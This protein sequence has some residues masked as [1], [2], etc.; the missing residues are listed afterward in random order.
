MWLTI[1]S[2]SPRPPCVRVLPW[3]A[4]WKCSNAWGRNSGLI[5]MPVVAARA[6][7]RVSP[8]AST[9]TSHRARPRA[10][11]FT[12]LAARFQTTCCSRSG[13]AEHA[14]PARARGPPP[15]WMRRLSRRG[16]HRRPARAPPPS[17]GRPASA[18]SAACRSR[19]ARRRAGP[20]SSCACSRALRS[21]TSSACA[22]LAPA[23]P[24]RCAASWPSPGSA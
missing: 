22:V 2:P 5:P 7:G 17:A 24:A 4:C 19:C 6:A 18:P 3:L 8:S 9:R 20:R 10:L 15:R 11:N 12:A 1:A 13:S 23:P 16:A 14:A 21:I